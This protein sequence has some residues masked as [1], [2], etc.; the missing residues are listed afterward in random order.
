MLSTYVPVRSRT[1]KSKNLDFQRLYFFDF[2]VV[3]DTNTPPT[4]FIF[5]LFK[6]SMILYQ[7]QHYSAQYVIS[8]SR[9]SQKIEKIG[10]FSDIFFRFFAVF[11]RIRLQSFS[12]SHCLKCVRCSIK[13]TTTQPRSCFLTRWRVKKLKNTDFQKFGILMVRPTMRWISISA[14]SDFNEIFSTY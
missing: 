10:I 4:L 6:V 12:F 8:C 14:T 9:K 2:L 13:H 11:T 3:F 1:K 7:T 5:A